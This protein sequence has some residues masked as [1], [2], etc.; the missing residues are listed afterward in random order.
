MLDHFT[1]N[2]GCFEATKDL[3]KNCWFYSQ[4]ALMVEMEA[5]AKQLATA[6]AKYNTKLEKASHGAVRPQ[7]QEASQ[8][9]TPRRMYWRRTV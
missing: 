8:D 4:D 1:D 6:A 3:D 9:T 5:F 2:D 7:A